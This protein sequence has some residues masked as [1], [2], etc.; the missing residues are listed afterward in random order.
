MSGLPVLDSELVKESSIA[1]LEAL[2]LR[3]AASA[4]P[5]PPGSAAASAATAEAETCEA[6]LRTLAL[7]GLSSGAMA[8]QDKSAPSAAAA[9]AAA[10]RLKA[11]RALLRL[12]AL[13]PSRVRRDVVVCALAEVCAG[14]AARARSRVRDAC[15]R[16][17]RRPSSLVAPTAGPR[18][19][20][21]RL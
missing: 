3:S 15:R 6:L 20:V 21:A 16:L 1:P 14:E 8:G 17:R 9:T 18:R 13:Y 5:L 10:G 7:S 4:A 12:Y 2:L 19:A 11:G